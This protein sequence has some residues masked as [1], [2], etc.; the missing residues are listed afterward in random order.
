MRLHLAVAWRSTED[1]DGLA[2]VEHDV[3]ALLDPVLNLRGMQGSDVRLELKGRRSKRGVLAAPALPA[4][5][6]DGAL[7]VE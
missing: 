1:A 6:A 7:G 4:R 5:G 3:L 2:A